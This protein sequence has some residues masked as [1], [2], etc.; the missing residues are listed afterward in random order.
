MELD[1]KGNC[2]Q[3]ISFVINFENGFRIRVIYEFK[4]SGCYNKVPKLSAKLT[5]LCTCVAEL[6]VPIIKRIT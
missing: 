6:L 1:N 2:A 4:F 3:R 5:R